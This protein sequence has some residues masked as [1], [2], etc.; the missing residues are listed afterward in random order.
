MEDEN[1]EKIIEENTNSE[2]G[3][4]IKPTRNNIFFPNT[5][6][7]INKKLF[8]FDK[9]KNSLEY[10]KN[11]TIP[12]KTLTKKARCINIINFKKS[13]SNNKRDTNINQIENKI[14]KEK[15]DE[16]NNSKNGSIIFDRAM[17]ICQFLNHISILKERNRLNKNIDYSLS[18]KKSKKR[19]EK[20]LINIK[21][22]KIFFMPETIKNFPK[23][24]DVKNKEIEKKTN[25]NSF[26]NEMIKVRSVNISDSKTGK[27]NNLNL[28]DSIKNIDIILTKKNQIPRIKF[29]SPNNSYLFGKIKEKK[30]IMFNKYFNMKNKA[31]FNLKKSRDHTKYKS[32]FNEIVRNMRDKFDVSFYINKKNKSFFENSK[33][34]QK[35]SSSKNYY[36]NRKIS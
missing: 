25:I 20:L 4:R 22:K 29:F 36:I 9:L 27:L 7:R 19:E 26:K 1:N 14:S 2:N 35:F 28:S 18:L 32:K 24:K 6:L 15:S 21:E 3:Y 34:E 17:N 10:S 30:S 13:L 8:L 33:G 31:N 23:P 12:E 11:S 16:K 5:R